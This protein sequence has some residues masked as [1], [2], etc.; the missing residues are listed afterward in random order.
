MKILI[1]SSV[2]YPAI[3][4]IE[5]L[6]LFLSQEFVKAGHEVK[7]ITGQKQ[8]KP[9]ENIEVVRTRSWIR[10]MRLF[11]WCDVFFMP[12]I[13]LK[14]VWL[15]LLNFRRKWVISH[16]DF[17]LMHSGWWKA[18][19]KMFFIRK[20][21][22]NIA[23]SESV[24]NSLKV[25]SRV[26]YNCYDND[27]FKVYPGIERDLDFVFVGRLVS[28]KGCGLLLDALARLGG[29][30]TLSIVGDGAEMEE[31][32]NKV[33]AFGLTGRVSF[34]GFLG[35]EE[36][37]MALGRHK[38]MV[39]PSSDLEGFGIVALEGLACGCDLIVSDAG[40]L[41][42]AVVGNGRVFPMG[43]V[44]KLTELMRESITNKNLNVMDPGRIK[45]LEEHSKAAIAKRY[46]E[47]FKELLK[48][49]V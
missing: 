2:F 45:F 47:A 31:M 8:D 43:D 24:S 28:Q 49:N 32:Q 3:G 29:N 14:G 1:C 9:L 11:L 16:N 13:T 22:M 25:N 37:A 34:T 38:V 21:H 10:Q 41:P 27:V 4:G 23:V 30:H 42:E 7:V 44:E 18:T 26:I 12:N 15:M 39:V 5:N 20:A 19:L 36:L 48:K 40:G 17:H 33:Q 46:L 35:H 6:T